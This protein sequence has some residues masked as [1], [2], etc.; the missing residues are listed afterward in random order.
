MRILFVA[1]GSSSHTA[2]WISQLRGENW[3][4][5]LFPVDEYYLYPDL[6]DVTV[7]QL[8]RYASSQR[9]DTTVRQATL[10]W[11]FQRGRMRIRNAL[12]RLPGNPISDP[13][14]LARLIRSL[15]PDI[16]HSMDMRGA[17][18]TLA[19][20][21]KL[22]GSFPQWIHTSWGS[23]LF[24]FGRQ[25]GYEAG[26]RGALA[27]CGFLMADCQRELDL[28]PEFGFNR[29]VLGVFPGAGGFHIEEMCQFRQV[30]PVSSRRVI[31]LKGRQ[32]HLGGRALVAL[33]ALHMCAD[34]LGKYEIVIYMPQG[35]SIVPY[36]AEYISLVTGLRIRVM[37]EHSP[38]EE[39][40]RLMGSARIAISVGMTDGTP[41]SMLEAMVMGAFPIQSNTAD[42][43]GWVED[44]RNALLVPPEDA[45]AIA[46]AIRKA[47]SDDAMVDEAD[48]INAQR[49]R[50]RI[51]IS[52]IKPRVIE[53]YKAIAAQRPSALKSALEAREV[54]Q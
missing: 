4:L 33:Q 15:K 5:H 2:R 31:M 11:P 54:F 29:E 7:H 37:P 25:E 41:H 46:A 50:D 28:A 1:F 47:V 44:S 23:D 17:I 49:T 26:I 14:R 53:T 32:G 19:G 22:N 42:T 21:E 9:I 51:D 24:Y 39:I 36:A 43:R 40:L 34:A 52:V 48:E 18:L 38:Y 13:A 45:E 10:W 6:R 8:F 27:T 12:R 3:D 20:Y 35:D 16:V 30:G